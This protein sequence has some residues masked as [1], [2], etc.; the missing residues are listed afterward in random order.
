MTHRNYTE[1]HN[2]TVIVVLY[3]RVYIVHIYKHKFTVIETVFSTNSQNIQGSDLEFIWIKNHL[4][5]VYNYIYKSQTR[6]L[7]TILLE[8][9]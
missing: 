7:G 5:Y 6:Q 4:S 8:F 2:A 9:F 3:L 1:S